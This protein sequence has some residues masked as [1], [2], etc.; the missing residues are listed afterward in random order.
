MT[1]RLPERGRPADEILEEMATFGARDANYR[2]G[3]T[4]SLVYWAGD[5]HHELVRRAHDLYLAGNAL[6]PMAFRSLKR[7]EA[8]VVQISAAL[9][10]G[11]A[12]TVGT[13][14]SG[15]T[16]SL[17]CAVY[18]ARERAAA[19]W[20]WIRRPNAVVPVTIH[21]AV[22]K[23]AHAFG[24][25][26][27]KARVDEHG[28]ADVA[29][30]RRLVDRNTILMMGSAPSYPWGVVD[31][32]PELAAIAAAKRVP[33]HVDACFGGFVLPWLER[34][35]V[36]VPRWD[37]RVP[38]VTSISAD[39]HKYGYAAKGAS[40][41]L[42]RD[43]ELLK[44]QLFVETGWPGGIYA[45]PTLAG[46]RPGGPIAAAWAAL[47]GMGEEGYLAKAKEAWAVAEALR[48]G[49]ADIP[50]LRLLGLPH[51]TVVSYASADPA[52]DV[53]AVA[54]Q[55]EARGWSVDRQQKPPSI[56][57]SANAANQPAVASYLADL[58]EAVRAV[59]ADPSL[60]T[61]GEA[62]V[63]GLMSSVPLAAV[64]RK[65]VRDVLAG[66]YAPG[67]TEAGVGGS[68]PNVETAARVLRKAKA[69]VGR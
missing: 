23:A 7:M 60:S 45:S 65:A 46:T 44:H 56:H 9:L 10:G 20:P 6:N 39:L 34:L 50:E 18:A 64:T 67:V 15:G 16:E 35:G 27:K 19:K 28:R 62:A 1:A 14:T 55:L 69:L 48:S 3:R 24:V 31:P 11:D 58:R 51:S 17:L 63:Y 43:L 29:H 66:M 40:V 49:I 36:P 42:Y 41:V 2:D 12:H 53:Y 57:C 38:G 5:A 13:M 8:E 25:R 33:F 61:R 54:D 30:A 26:L 68:D 37:L 21:P 52:V 32:I 22:D 47:Q 59:K 4:W